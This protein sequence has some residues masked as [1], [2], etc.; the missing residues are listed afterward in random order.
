MSRLWAT[1]VALGVLCASGR[2]GWIVDGEREATGTGSTN[3]AVTASD[4]SAATGLFDGILSAT[5]TNVQS[6]LE[7]LDDA[8]SG[9][10][11]DEGDGTIS[12]ASTNETVPA[13]S[14]SALSPSLRLTETNQGEYALVKR[15]AGSNELLVQNRVAMPAGSGQS[16]AFTYNY[17]NPNVVTMANEA[18]FDF[19]RTDPFSVECWIYCTDLGNNIYGDQVFSK[20]QSGYRGISALVSPAGSISVNLTS[21]SGPNQISFNTGSATIIENT[22]HHVVITYDGSSTADGVTVYVNDSPKTHYNVVDSLTST[23]LT[24]DPF[25][26]G[27]YGPFYKYRNFDGFI[28]EMV[29]YD[30]EL[31]AAEVSASYNS[32]AGTYH[33]QTADTVAIWHFDGD[34]LDATDNDNDGTWSGSTGESYGQGKMNVPSGNQLSTVVSSLDGVA[35]GEKGIHV[36][37]DPDGKAIVQG[38]TAVELKG[39]ST[40]AVHIDDD[41]LVGINNATPAEQLDVEGHVRVGS[42]TYGVVLGAGDDA[43]IHYDGADLVIDPDAA[44]SGVVRVD[45][46]LWCES[47]DIRDSGTSKFTVDTAGSPTFGR[48]ETFCELFYG[49]SGQRLFR[50]Y[51][52]GHTL[53][54]GTDALNLTQTTV[55]YSV[56]MGYRSQYSNIS[57]DNNITIGARSGEFLT[58]GDSVDIGFAAG[59]DGGSR[60]VAIGSYALNQTLGTS[61]NVGIGYQCGNYAENASKCAFVGALAGYGD[62]S[63]RL[64][65]EHLIGIGYSCMKD[66]ISDQAHHDIVIGG[67]SDVNGDIAYATVIGHGLVNSNS[68]SF[69]IGGGGTNYLQGTAHELNVPEHL[70]IGDALT[71]TPVAAP[72]VTNTG[73]IFY[74]SDD[75]KVKVWTGAAWENL[76]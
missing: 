23:I 33:T 75:G 58:G 49:T 11:T 64:D 8:S 6:A 7:T 12:R 3:G 53:A 59:Q 16:A 51:G 71:L 42:D 29:V 72:A 4:V 74:D 40:T 69:I 45:G 32:G 50:A 47:I 9:L 73:T 19:E 5:D 10:W 61:Y 39:G 17:D 37:G 52:N 21:V 68:A 70:T 35:G 18:N 60:Q 62:V 55:G 48:G 25:R 76:N 46:E 66:H 22:W 14:V 15:V 28:D 13:V 38:G 34:A 20:A 63:D 24:G 2:A 54:F 26:V 41:G 31:S 56:A 1:M 36:F 43:L 57:G 30:K 67:E 44:G 27:N 65:G